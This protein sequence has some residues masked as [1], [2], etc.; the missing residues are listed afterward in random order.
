MSDPED[1]TSEHPEVVDVA[2]IADVH[3]VSTRRQQRQPVVQ[4]PVLPDDVGEGNEGLPRHP[5]PM[6]EYRPEHIDAQDAI[7]FAAIELKHYYD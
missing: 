7:A 3:P 6:S 2:D 1:A 5:V 4:L